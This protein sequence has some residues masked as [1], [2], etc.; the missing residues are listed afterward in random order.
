MPGIHSRTITWRRAGDAR[1]LIAA[2]YALLLQVSHPTVGAGVS[3][4]SQFQRDPWGRLLRT[5]D[6]ACTIVYASPRA[7]GEMGGRIRSFHKQIKGTRPD[8][9]RYHALEPAAYAWVHATLAE[10]IVAAHERFGRP[11][12]DEQREQLW[13][14]WRSLGRLLGIRDGDLP[15]GWQG[16]RGYVAGMVG[17]ELQHTAAVDEVLTALAR[18]APP[19]LSTL[20]RPL[21]PVVRMPLGHFVGLTTTGLLP[22]ALR[23]RFGLDWTRA[24]ELEL[25]ALGAGLRTVTPLMPRSLR[26]TGPGYLRWRREAIARGDVASGT[27]E[28]SA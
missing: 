2:G 13:A 1:V 16:F 5:L 28:P 24:N 3:E 9:V 8:G 17:R 14:E 4:H 7:A 19:A 10:G 20:Y 21:W 12:S 22:P 11:F 25:R 26:N 15:E 18:P 23:A 6:Y 27:L